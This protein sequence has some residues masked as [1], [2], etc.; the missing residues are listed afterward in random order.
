LLLL[1]AVIASAGVVM[2]STATVI[3]A[4][5]VAPLMTPILGVVLSVVTVDSRNLGISLLLVATG[6]A[7]VVAV[8]W[9]LGQLTPVPVVAATNSQ[10]AGRVDPTLMDLLAALATGAVGS[11][12]LV[13]ADVSD[14]LPGVAIAIS[15]VPPLAVVG[16]TLESGAP[17]QAQGAL[18]LFLTNVGAILLSGLIVMAI[19]RVRATA[20][21]RW[22]TPHANSR[23]A[24]TV[25]VVFVIAL[26][27]PLAVDSQQVTSQELTNADVTTAAADWAKTVGWQVVDVAT[28]ESAVTVRAIGPLRLPD[29]Q[30]LRTA[31]DANGLKDTSVQLELDPVKRVELPGS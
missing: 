26:V 29:P 27:A 7:V 23:L 6:A 13:R 4:M 3:G 9:L 21:Q 24:V 22:R 20:A 2:D 5:I 8:G 25:V 28:T 11:F 1:A 17:E 18:L 31:L 30:T 19:Y 10:V 14:T 15:L 12:A 16:L